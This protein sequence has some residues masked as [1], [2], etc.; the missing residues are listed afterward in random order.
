LP[1]GTIR[2]GSPPLIGI[3][4]MPLRY[5]PEQMAANG[6]SSLDIGLRH[7]VRCA[8]LPWRHRDPFDRLLIS[9]ALEED[10]AV[11]SR[12]VIFESC[13]VRRIW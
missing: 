12:D 5:V 11:V 10:L 9:Q 4:Q 8:R 2:F 3:T 13:G 1:S 6:F 7:V